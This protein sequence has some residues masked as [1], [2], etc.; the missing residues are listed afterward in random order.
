MAIIKAVNS[1]ASIGRGINY[2]TQEEKTEEKLIS[3][4]NCNPETAIDEMK[5][6]KEINS[7]TTGR[8][9]YHFIQSFNPIDRVDPQTAHKLGKEWLERNDKFKG[10]EIVLA[11][12]VDKEHTH[13]H[14]IINSVSFE[15]GMK[16]HTN[17]KEYQKMKEISNQ[18][19][20]ENGLTIPEKSQEKGKITSFNQN[21]YQAMKRHFEGNYKSYVIDTAIAVSQVKETATSKYD[22]IEKMEQQGYTTNWKDTSKN[23]TFIN[24]DT[25]KRVRLSNLEKTFNDNSFTKGGLIN[26]F[27]RN[28]AERETSRTSQE[29]GNTDL[30][31]RTESENIRTDERDPRTQSTNEKLYSSSHGQGHS[32]S[33]N[34][35]ER[36]TSNRGNEQGISRA[37]DFDIGKARE[38]VNKATRENAR[39]IEVISKPDARTRE[40]EQRKIR[41]LERANREQHAERVEPTKSRSWEHER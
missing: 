9:Y 25:G 27:E 21:K 13:N 11:T 38:Y 7:K 41:E 32:K 28:K 34:N 29:R 3:G 16:L 23:V 20:R 26:E 6:T 39:N 2:I 15:T 18:I 10:Y 31:S 37:N 24:Q 5:A 36:D 19:S 4:I 1:K 22:F 8:Q 30:P 40:N 33:A 12:H 14:F 35:F 17:K